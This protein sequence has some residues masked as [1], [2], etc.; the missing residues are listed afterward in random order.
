MSVPSGT[1]RHITKHFFSLR[2]EKKHVLPEK[3]TQGEEISL[4][5]LSEKPMCRESFSSPH[6]RRRF[7]PRSAE[8]LASDGSGS[9]EQRRISRF[10]LFF[11]LFFF[12]PRLIPPDSDRRQSKST[13]SG[14]FRVVTRQKQ[15]QS[16]IPPSSRQFGP[17]TVQR[18]NR[19][20]S[21]VQY[22]SKH[23]TLYKSFFLALDGDIFV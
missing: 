21:P 23:R 10:T 11:S 1:L 19:Y 9:R 4:R 15:S 14:R 13:V 22:D 6:D 18:V 20:V 16:T 12:L 5:S 17:C 3:P 8:K 2:W 7:S